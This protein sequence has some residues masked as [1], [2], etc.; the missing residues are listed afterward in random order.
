MKY[1]IEIIT[2]VDGRKIYIPQVKNGFMS[3]WKYIHGDG[4]EYTYF[5]CDCKSKESALDIIDT[6]YNLT[7]RSKIKS[8]EIE[9]ITK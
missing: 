3:S 4:D 1:R 6:H 8:I 5:S 7:Q 9:Y 2:Y